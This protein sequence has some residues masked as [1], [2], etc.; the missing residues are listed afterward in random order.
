MAGDHVELELNY[1]VTYA[2]TMIMLEHE[3]YFDAC[4]IKQK[5]IDRESLNQGANKVP[6]SS[7]FRPCPSFL[8]S[9]LTMVRVDGVLGILSW[10]CKKT[11]ETVEIIASSQLEQK[12]GIDIG[13]KLHTAAPFCFL[14]T[15]L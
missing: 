3:V 5:L 2:V 4:L 10:Q 9:L 11:D 14:K 7:D 12:M 8:A 15:K 13:A 1:I 6:M